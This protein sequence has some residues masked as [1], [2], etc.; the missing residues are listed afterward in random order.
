MNIALNITT[1]ITEFLSGFMSEGAANIGA[2]VAI[3]L[4]YLAIFAVAGLY[5][6][7]LER[8][9]AAIFGPGTVISESAI[10]IMELYLEQE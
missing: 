3:A 1:T 2:M 10:K 9:V 8:K 7:L 5:L 6:V 4:I